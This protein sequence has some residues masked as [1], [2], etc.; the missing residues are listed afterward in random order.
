[1]SA[2]MTI[3]SYLRKAERALAAAQLLLSNG[4][5][6]GACNRAYYAMFD[7]AH[8]ALCASRLDATPFI[9]THRGLMNA[10]GLQLV[11]TGRLPKELGRTLNEIEQV[12]LLADYTDTSIKP[13]KAAWAVEQAERFVR[14]IRDQFIPETEINAQVNHS[15]KM[16][17]RF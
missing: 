3:G 11:Q 14:T 12:R 9:K 7:A 13:D 15:N 16:K 2:S 8:A 1:M 4:E 5:V 6:E 17:P 10:F